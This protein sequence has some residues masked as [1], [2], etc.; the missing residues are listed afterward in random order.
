MNSY[1]GY[2]YFFFSSFLSLPMSFPFFSLPL[3]HAH[4]HIQLVVDNRHQKDEDRKE[5]QEDA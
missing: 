3:L 1:V 2:A 4:I 5:E